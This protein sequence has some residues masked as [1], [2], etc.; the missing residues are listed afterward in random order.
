M[1][2]IN[3]NSGIKTY[4][5]NGDESNV[6]KVNISDINIAQ[7]IKETEEKI[8]KIGVEIDNGVTAEQ[9]SAYDKEIKDLINYTFGTDIC[10]PAFGNTNVFSITEEGKFLFEAFFEAF[11]PIITEDIQNYKM[12]KKSE[13]F[14]SVISNAPAVDTPANQFTEEEKELLR[15]KLGI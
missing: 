10:T 5:V 2:S 13:K 11:V 9:L 7:R 1:K 12:V 15:Q 4:A 3:F 6:I 14:N 8:D